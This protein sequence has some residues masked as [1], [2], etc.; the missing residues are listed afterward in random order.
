MIAFSTCLYKR[1]IC[2]LLLLYLSSSFLQAQNLITNGGFESYN[3][4]PSGTKS[5]PESDGQYLRT[6]SNEC[7][8]AI[9]TFDVQTVNCKNCVEFPTAFTPNNDGRNDHFKALFR[10][11]S[12]EFY[13]RIY[14]R[15]GECV[16][17]SYDKDFS[18]DGTQNGI[19]APIGTYM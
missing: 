2:L 6:E 15:W 9:D 1:L 12:N 11:P 17:V 4:C 18:W 8:Y 7:G 19:P 16:F 13:M 10:C 3:A 5:I 14:N